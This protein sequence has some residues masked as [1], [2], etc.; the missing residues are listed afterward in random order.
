MA[1]EDLNNII[2]QVEELKDSELLYT[3][4]MDIGKSLSKK[5]K[6]NIRDSTNFVN[7]CQSQVWITGSCHNDTWFFDFD[8]DAFIVQGIGGL[9]LKVFNGQ[10]ADQIKNITF[11]DFKPFAQTL[12]TQRQRGLQAIINRIHTLVG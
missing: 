2:K 4:I 12:S 7:G 1:L 10:T 11:H 9:V 6:S 8:S 5:R 3:W